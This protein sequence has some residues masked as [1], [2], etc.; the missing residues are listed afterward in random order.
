MT[1]PLLLGVDS[2][3]S[4]VK[5]VAFDRAGRELAMARR[6]VTIHTPLPGRSE[7]DMHQAWEAAAATM[8]DV[9]KAVGGERIAAVG[10]AGT[11]CGF[12]PID[13]AGRP[14]RRAILWN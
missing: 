2:G 13:D 14:V 5:S 11:T 1:G 10:I 6:E 9:A 4:W 7:V 3:T 8:A 12:W